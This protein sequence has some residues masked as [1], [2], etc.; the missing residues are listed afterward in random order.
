MK[1]D[2]FD[3]LLTGLRGETVDPAIVDQAAG[4][5]RERLFPSSASSGG[6]GITASLRTCSDFRALIPSYL[7]RTLSPAKSLLLVDHTHECVECRRELE[8]SRSGNVRMLTRPVAVSNEVS[9]VTRWSIAAMV[10]LGAGLGAWGI[11]NSLGVPAGARATVQSV[12]GIL[13]QVAD[14]SS[15]PVF[16]GGQLTE[17]QVVRT[18]KDSKAMLKLADGSMV[19]MNE[20]SELSI[21]RVQRGTTIALDRGNVIVHAAKQRSGALYVKTADCEVMVKGTIFAVTRG[22]K[23]SRV[24]V[25]EGSVKVDQGT[26]SQM[27]KPG[28]QVATSPSVSRVPVQDDV[29]WSQDAAKYLAMLGELS[30]L[31]KDIEKI[32]GTGLRTSSKLLDYIPG[33]TLLYAAIP[34]LGTTLTQANQ[35]FEER[36]QASP[37]LKEWWGRHN[38]NAAQLKE[39]VQKFRTISDYLGDEIVLAYATNDS[40]ERGGSPIIMAET[41]REGLREYL[42]AEVATLNA[43]AGQH[44]VEIVDNASNLRSSGSEGRRSMKVYMAHGV[45]AMSPESA[46]VQELADRLQRPAAD[47]QGGHA[48]SRPAGVSIRRE[49]VVLRRPGPHQLA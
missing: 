48:E 15:T 29:A 5:V 47:R 14:R 3:N 40:G 24:S 43:K 1:T 35:L 11:V 10:A 36:V 31:Q 23:G 30:G 41:K 22:T 12:S 45:V 21:S 37:V 46:L 42:Q 18:A 7:N 39:M 25:V 9:P 20:R 4:R 17:R 49:L 26:T 27:L 8:T 33:D 32:P 2:N 16:S 28:D 44:A 38:N 19:E 6:P 13:Y 34:N